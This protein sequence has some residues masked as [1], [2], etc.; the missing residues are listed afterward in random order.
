MSKTWLLENILQTPRTIA[1]L[2]GNV[3]KQHAF[4][5]EHLQP[6]LTAAKNVNDGSLDEK[7][8]KKITHYYGLAVP[9]ILGEEICALR[10]SSMSQRERMA[11]MYQ[12]AMTGLGDD[13]FDKQGTSTETVKEFIEHPEQFT[14]HTANERLFLSFY[15]K[16][17]E[18]AH[19][20]SLVKKY[21]R[22]VFAAQVE[23]KKQAAPGLTRDEIMKITL[24]KGGTSVL[25]Y[26]A[27][28]SHFFGEGEEEA[29]YKIGGLMQFGNDVFGVYDDRNENIATLLTT[30]KKIAEVR[31]IFRS[32]MDESFAAVY[33]AGYPKKNVEK[34]LRLISMSLCSRCF[35]C[36]D[37]LEKKEAT[38]NNVFSPAQYSRNDLVCDMDK[39]GNKWKSVAWH[40]KH[41]LSNR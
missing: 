21:L 18:H 24:D 20:A 4:I 35:V 13:F 32:I 11:L 12:G 23:S 37:Q 2:V 8:F 16:S 9:A 39:A 25:F 15:K 38:T 10:G 22:K 27:A 40:I 6:E 26:R 14:G 28:M 1:A 36:F 30:T 31:T 33:D 3:K 7:D 17:L 5:R 19:D 29:L 34:F 41:K